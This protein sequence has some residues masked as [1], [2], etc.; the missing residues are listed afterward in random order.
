MYF[1]HIF[2][3]PIYTVIAIFSSFYQRLIKSECRRG[4][5]HK[6][7]NTRSHPPHLC[8]ASFRVESVGLTVDGYIEANTLCVLVILGFNGMFSAPHCPV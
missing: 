1:C 6:Y 5:F 4:H 8:F 3:F 2:D 7:A